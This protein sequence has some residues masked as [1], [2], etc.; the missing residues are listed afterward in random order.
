MGFF[1]VIPTGV[2]GVEGPRIPATCTGTSLK[3]RGGRIVFEV[4]GEGQIPNSADFLCD[5][6]RSEGVLLPSV[7]LSEVEGS[8]PVLS[9]LEGRSDAPS[10]FLVSF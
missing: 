2:R 10:F 9:I 3:E 1:C 8:E 4:S 7:I 5:P 6:E